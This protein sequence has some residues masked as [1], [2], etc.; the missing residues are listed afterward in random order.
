M[1]MS[2]TLT[3]EAKYMPHGMTVGRTDFPPEEEFFI[4][5]E[6]QDGNKIYFLASHAG[7]G[8][9]SSDYLSIPENTE[10]DIQFKS[11]GKAIKFVKDHAIENIW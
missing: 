3:I 9:V 8:M 11:L 1:S 10:L 4:S 5:A 2:I 7:K 6:D